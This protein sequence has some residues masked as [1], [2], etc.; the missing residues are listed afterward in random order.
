MCK[1]RYIVDQ[2]FITIR[3]AILLKKTSE[4]N[5]FFINYPPHRIDTLR[6]LGSPPL[7]PVGSIMAGCGSRAD[8]CPSDIFSPPPPPF[9]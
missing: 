1:G 7:F 3:A 4:T 2:L 5:P 6:S 9:L 8:D